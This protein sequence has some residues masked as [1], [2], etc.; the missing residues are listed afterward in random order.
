MRRDSNSESSDDIT[1]ERSISQVAPK[2]KAFVN[3]LVRAPQREYQRIAVHAVTLTY[4][5]MFGNE[6]RTIYSDWNK[7]EYAFTWERPD[8]LKGTLPR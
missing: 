5:D 6:Y 4:D 3:F 2:E 8:S 1:D 7:N